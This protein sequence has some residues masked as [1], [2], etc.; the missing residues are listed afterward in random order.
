MYA[1]AAKIA[2]P[3]QRRRRRD[4]RV[5]IRCPVG[6]EHSLVVPQ[7]LQISDADALEVFRLFDRRRQ[8]Y[9]VERD[10]RRVFAINGPQY[11]EFAERFDKDSDGKVTFEEFKSVLRDIVEEKGDLSIF[12]RIYVTLSEPSSSVISR[13]ISLIIMALIII[14]TAS[15]VLDTIPQFKITPYRS[16]CCGFNQDVYAR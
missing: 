1:G 13:W 7:T 14:S 4:V 11:A 5:Q 3:R 9:F 8:G 10:V 15:F 16:S 12:E 2:K 6:V